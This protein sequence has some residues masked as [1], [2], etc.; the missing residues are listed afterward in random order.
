MRIVL[1]NN[2]KCLCFF[3]DLRKH[4]LPLLFY[5]P[6]YVNL[7]SQHSF[8]HSYTSSEYNLS[9]I[10]NLKFSVNRIKNMFQDLREDCKIDICLLPGI[11]N[12]E[13]STV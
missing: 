8:I 13:L 2:I 1:N 6:L 10:R 9:F 11:L 3:L 4:K 5:L 7:H 12:G